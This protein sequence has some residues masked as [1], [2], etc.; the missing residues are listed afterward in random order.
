MSIERSYA[1]KVSLG[2]IMENSSSPPKKQKG[3][4]I[5]PLLPHFFPF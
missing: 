2:T 3:A 4:G 1:L 5:I